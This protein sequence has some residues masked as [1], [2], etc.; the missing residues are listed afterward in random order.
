MSLTNVS[1][2]STLISPSGPSRVN[3]QPE[4]IEASAGLAFDTVK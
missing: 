4:R 3:V 1:L 2:D